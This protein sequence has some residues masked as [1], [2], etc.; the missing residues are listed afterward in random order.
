MHIP[1]KR[2][3]SVQSRQPKHQNGG[4]LEQPSDVKQSTTTVSR[5]RASSALPERVVESNAMPRTE[6]E[7]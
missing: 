2:A 7:K 6:K 5:P 4:Q 1:R 3:S